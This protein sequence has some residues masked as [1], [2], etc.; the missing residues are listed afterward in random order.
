MI[1]PQALVDP[2]AKIGAG[3]SIGPFSVIGPEVEIGSGTWI[4]PHVVIQ[5]RTQIG[6]DNRIFQFSSIGE[7][8][9][10]KKYANEP[11]RLIIGDRNV[12]REGA[13][14]HLGTV[15]DEGLTQIGHDNLFMAN[16]HVAHDCRI[17]NHNILVNHAALAGH[18]HVGDHVIISGFCGVHQFCQIGSHAF[19]VHA[20]TI[21]MDVPPYV[22]V[23]GGATTT[24]KGINAEG[25]KRRGFSPEA[26]KGLWQAYKILYRQG[27]LLTQ[28]MDE[29]AV[30]N[31]SCPEVQILLDFLKSSRRGIVR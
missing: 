25:L 24:T 15:Q 11:T 5:G 18:V 17:G 8:P 7:V 6:C 10:D 13:T 16:V 26:I 1:H 31:Q 14:I 27:L 3:V 22:I 23:T 28:A 4:G 20:C 29:L 19:L 2:A 12:I 30:L 21:S 9:Q